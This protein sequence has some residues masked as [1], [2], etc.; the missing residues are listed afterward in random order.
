MD[1]YVRIYA[2]ISSFSLQSRPVLT[3][4]VSDYSTPYMMKRSTMERSLHDVCVRSQLDES[5]V[6]I[7]LRMGGPYQ[8]QK[9]SGNAP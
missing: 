8:A 2:F 9:K 3:N 4:E 1:I 5:V 6:D 7:Y